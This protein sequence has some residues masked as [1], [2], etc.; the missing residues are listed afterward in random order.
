MQTT[1]KIDQIQNELQ[2]VLGI[3]H[4]SWEYPGFFV[5]YANQGIFNLG[6]ANDCWGWNDA[7]GKLSGDTIEIEPDKIVRDFADW[8]NS[9]TN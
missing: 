7:E 5:I 8:M 6:Q 1:D 9:E 3:W 2:Q 4:V